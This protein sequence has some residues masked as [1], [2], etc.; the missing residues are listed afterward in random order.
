MPKT[1][2]NTILKDGSKTTVDT[3]DYSSRT[4]KEELKQLK[5]KSETALQN[6]EVSIQKLSKFIIKK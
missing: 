2:I 3:I 1:N 4:K 5:E 6:K